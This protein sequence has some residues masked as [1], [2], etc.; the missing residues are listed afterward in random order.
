M[1]R[2]ARLIA[3]MF[4]ANSVLLPASITTTTSGQIAD[5]GTVLA[6][7][8]D[9]G[10]TSSTCTAIL[11]ANP[12]ITPGGR[13]Q[14]S[15]AGDWNTVTSATEESV[16]L[17]CATPGTRATARATWTVNDTITIHGSTGSAFLLIEFMASSFNIGPTGHYTL[18]VN[19][20]SAD[21]TNVLGVIPGAQ[22]LLPAG[23]FVVPFVFDVPFPLT[24]GFSSEGFSSGD[25]VITSGRAALVPAQVFRT[26]GFRLTDP[27]T[28]FQIVRESGASFGVPEPGTLT[29]F[30][31]ALAFA[32]LAKLTRRTH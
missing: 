20:T 30:A 7:C 8:A 16:D 31:A 27:I 18:F 28:D 15:I 29:M 24:F 3:A 1:Y 6:S 5:Q 10:Q 13:A 32:S 12:P 9:T 17:C 4:I 25:T 2:A 11:Q 22:A 19:G 26:D 21:V 23:G 14:A